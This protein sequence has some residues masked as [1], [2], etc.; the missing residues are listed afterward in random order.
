[1]ATAWPCAVLCFVLELSAAYM[2][3]VLRGSCW[4]DANACGDAGAV[5]KKL[6]MGDEG[7]E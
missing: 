6:D 4:N 3:C 2:L 1:M 7:G 5:G